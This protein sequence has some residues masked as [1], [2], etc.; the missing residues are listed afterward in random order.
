[1]NLLNDESFMP[2][3]DKIL[4]KYMQKANH[5][6]IVPLIFAGFFCGTILHYLRYKIQVDEQKLVENYGADI[7]YFVKRKYQQLM[8]YYRAYYIHYQRFQLLYYLDE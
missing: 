2:E 7:P 3:R 4:R 1:M 8:H 5:T 6:F